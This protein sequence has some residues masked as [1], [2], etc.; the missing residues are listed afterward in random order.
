MST[1]SNEVHNYGIAVEQ[2]I[3]AKGIKV[4]KMLC[5]SLVPLVLYITPIHVLCA[6]MPSFLMVY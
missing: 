3:G 4:P 2:N 5:A 1:F 6:Y